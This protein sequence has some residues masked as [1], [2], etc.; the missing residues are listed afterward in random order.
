MPKVLV[1]HLTVKKPN[2]F[3]HVGEGHDS[4][5]WCSSCSSVVESLPV[6]IWFFCNKN[7][8]QKQKC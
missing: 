4:E 5:Q 3:C 2:Q 7:K 1:D 8:E 6:N